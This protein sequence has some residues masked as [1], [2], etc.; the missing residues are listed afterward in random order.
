MKFDDLF[1]SMSCGE[2]VKADFDFRLLEISSIV[3]L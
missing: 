1:K 3:G 2:T